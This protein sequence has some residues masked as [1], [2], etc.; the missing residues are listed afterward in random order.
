[1]TT[2]SLIV[3][4]SDFPIKILGLNTPEFKPAV[5]AVV[6][7]HAHDFDGEKI[8]CRQSQADKYQSITCTVRATSRTQLDALYQELVDHPL[9]KMVL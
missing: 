9:V 3:Y 4:P 7:R 6:Q 1:M 8:E 5:L 2:D